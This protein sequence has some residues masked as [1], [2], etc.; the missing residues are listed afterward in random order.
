MISTC[1]SGPIMSRL[2]CLR[3]ITFD[4]VFVRHRGQTHFATPFESRHASIFWW[5]FGHSV[6]TGLQSVFCIYIPS[7]FPNAIAWFC[8]SSL[9]GRDLQHQRT[10]RL[11]PYRFSFGFG[12]KAVKDYRLNCAA[13]C[14]GVRMGIFTTWLYLSSCTLFLH[15]SHINHPSVSLR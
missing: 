7:L 8:Q 9:C 2:M 15:F 13:N 12:A 10:A 14:C 3:P 5:Q 1:P 6:S 4:T 11:H